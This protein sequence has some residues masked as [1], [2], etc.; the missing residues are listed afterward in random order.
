VD[1]CSLEDTAV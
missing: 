1:V